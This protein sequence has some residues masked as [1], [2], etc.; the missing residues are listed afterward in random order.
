MT[1]SDVSILVQ[2]R[3]EAGYAIDAGRNMQIISEEMDSAAGDIR[4]DLTHLYQAWAWVGRVEHLRGRKR[5]SMTNNPGIASTLFSWDPIESGAK[6]LLTQDE[7]TSVGTT[8]DGDKSFWDTSLNCTI[9]QSSRRSL[10]LQACG[11]ATNLRGNAMNTGERLELE[12]TDTTTLEHAMRDSE[13]IGDYE[14]SA[15]LATFHGDLR[16]AVGALRRAQNALCQEFE[17]GESR[18]D[19][20]DEV[21]QLLQ[22]V[23]MSIAGYSTPRNEDSSKGNSLWQDMCRTLLRHPFLIDSSQTSHPYL[24]TVCVFLLLASQVHANEADSEVGAQTR[25]FDDILY[26]ERLSLE[27]RTAFACR[28]LPSGELHK[29]LDY[30]KSQAIAAG[31]LDGIIILGLGTEGRALLQVR[32]YCPS[33]MWIHTVLTCLFMIIFIF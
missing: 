32:K 2:R 17:T 30:E 18:N 14:R 13:A 12:E 16:A 28:F 33:N 31:R 4:R 6:T 23:A 25:W 27:D 15:A 19:D 26:N 11:W 8:A 9:Y 1:E 21:H 5:W 24:R 7:A 3:A 22:L 29:F 10:V 20:K